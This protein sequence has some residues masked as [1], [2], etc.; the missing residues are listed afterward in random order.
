M[1]FESAPLFAFCTTEFFKVYHLRD[2]TENFAF[3]DFNRISK[4]D[5][6]SLFALHPFA[7]ISFMCVKDSNVIFLH[8]AASSALCKRKDNILLFWFT[9]Q[10]YSVEWNRTLRRF[11]EPSKSEKSIQGISEK[12]CNNNK[13]QQIL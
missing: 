4:R 3:S 8:V 7:T 11:N 2:F 6:K 1:L 12:L 13:V 10:F 9:M 5:V